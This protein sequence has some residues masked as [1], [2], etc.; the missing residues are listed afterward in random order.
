MPCSRQ[1]KRVEW[2]HVVDPGRVGKPRSCSS[3]NDASSSASNRKDS[4]VAWSP[5]D[6]DDPPLKKKQRTVLPARAS[7]VHSR[8]L[9]EPRPCYP[10]TTTTRSPKIHPLDPQQLMPPI[11]STSS[12]AHTSITLP[13]LSSIIRPEPLL[14]LMICP[15][16]LTGRRHQQRAAAGGQFV[17]EKLIEGRMCG[18]TFR[19]SYDL[20][21]HQTIHL[22]NRPYCY[23]SEC[24]KKFTRM[25]ALRR[26]E[27]VQGHHSSSSSST[28]RQD[29]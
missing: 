24:G 25:D 4:G 14:P 7:I 2:E 21:R 8:K 18:Q 3:D 11:Q 22:K 6:D 23:C 15:P 9:P 27:R 28:S 29:V 12:P 26:H 17:C 19:R 16:L 10:P 5:E 20:S 1:R 13:A